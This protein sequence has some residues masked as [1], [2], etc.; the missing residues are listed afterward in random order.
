MSTILSY[1]QGLV[2]TLVN[3]MPSQYQQ[4]SLQALLGLFLQAT[5]NSLPEHALDSER[6]RYQS[7]PLASSVSDAIGV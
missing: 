6:Q 5:G 7:L 2:Y 4:R 3:L 1:A